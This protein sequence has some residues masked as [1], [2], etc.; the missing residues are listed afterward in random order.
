MRAWT[1]KHRQWLESIQLEEAAQQV[2][3]SEYIHAVDEAKS[4]IER[5]EQEI[6]VYVETF[7]DQGVI[8]ALQ[9]L[10]GVELIAAATL[11]AELGDIT[12]FETAKQLM[13][14]A[15]VVPSEY[16]SGA[17][18]RRGSITK[19]GNAHVRRLIVQSAWN[20]RHSP[21]VGIELKKRQ[22]GLSQEIKAISWKAQM[23]LNRK[24]R[25]MLGR[26]KTKQVVVVPVAREL[27]GFIWAI[28]REV[29]EESEKRKV[30]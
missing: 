2:V 22:E 7:A 14:Y 11:V 17:K 1:Q 8:K 25:R 30:A 9:A 20:Y 16:S 10:R 19:S 12:R 27:L 18:E 26:A 13:S 4:R 23:R 3:V 28:A 24:Y 6:A 21:R 5:F 15:G 29:A